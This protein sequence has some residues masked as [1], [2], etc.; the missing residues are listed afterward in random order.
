MP[1][2]NLPDITGN[3]VNLR[4][5]KEPDLS[6]TRA[7]R[8]QD[9]IRQWFFN[10]DLIGAEQHQAWFEQYQKR[11]DDFTFIIEESVGHRAVGQVSL[12]HIDWANGRAEFGR[13]MIG[14]ADAVG[15]GLAHEATQLLVDYAL[16]ELGLCQ[17]YLEVWS[18]NLR[19]LEIYKRC[20]FVG[21]AENGGVVQ[22]EKQATRSK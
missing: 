18:N 5:L 4:L 19:A 17:V 6:L 1:K 7:W 11:D 8:N 14:V 9:H 21:V 15:K 10:S 3:R 12:Y 13:L 20:G 2:R 16:N 22:M